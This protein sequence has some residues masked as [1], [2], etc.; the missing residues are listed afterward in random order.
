MTRSSFLKILSNLSS[1]GV[2]FPPCEILFFE[3][4]SIGETALCTVRGNV[5]KENPSITVSAALNSK[6]ERQHC[7]LIEHKAMA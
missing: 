1:V 5:I 2:Q 4:F 3:I 7:E 6:T